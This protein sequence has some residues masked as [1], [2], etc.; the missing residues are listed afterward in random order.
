V[1]PDIDELKA[2]IAQDE[3][4][5]EDEQER[6]IRRTARIGVEGRAL[7]LAVAAI[8]VLR[9]KGTI[10][11]SDIC[12]LAEFLG[13]DSDAIVRAWQTR[14]EFDLDTTRYAIEAPI[15]KVRPIK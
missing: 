1:E 12:R 11:G 7:E 13:Y 8:E 2:L 4:Y 15:A 3:G 9:D 10:T 6:V 14:G 5:D